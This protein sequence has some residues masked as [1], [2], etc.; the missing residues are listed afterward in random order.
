[1][2]M[3]NNEADADTQDPDDI[4]TLLARATV[5]VAS[6]DADQDCA[7]DEAMSLSS[8][9]FVSD[10]C[11]TV[12]IDDPDFWT[13][14]VGTA[15]PAPRHTDT[16]DS[17]G[18]L[19]KRTIR[20]NMYVDD[21]N[22]D[23]YCSD[24]GDYAGEKKSK[25][26]KKKL[27]KEKR[28]KPAWRWKKSFKAPLAQQ[29]QSWLSKA[30]LT[31]ML[32]H[33]RRFGGNA[34]FYVPKD[35]QIAPAAVRRITAFLLGMC[36]AFQAVACKH[37]NTD[38]EACV[39]SMEMLQHNVYYGTESPAPEGDEAV[40]LS[41]A[42]PDL[43]TE[44]MATPD[45]GGVLTQTTTTP[46]GTELTAATNVV[47]VDPTVSAML[48]RLQKVVTNSSSPKFATSVRE[49]VLSEHRAHSSDE[50]GSVSTDKA[51]GELA[52]L[53]QSLDLPVAS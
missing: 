27:P 40:A 28:A 30:V 6:D 10:N 22:D 47:D 53:L 9:K 49:L 51:A 32:R 15:A 17:N 46:A 11:G 41:K 43:V 37:G 3:F 24:D 34:P 52:S 31:S 4:D 20:R 44:S 48:G 50:R 38:A 12:G 5:V 33:I 42:A 29:S 7:A 13:K 35:T 26:K 8:A 21:A 45:G 36:F 2:E 18:R 14:V 1:M 23:D 39:Q 19:R 25:S 16:E